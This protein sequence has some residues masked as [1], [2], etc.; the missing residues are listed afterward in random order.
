M[1]LSFD[2]VK[3]GGYVKVELKRKGNR[4]RRMQV[5]KK[6]ESSSENMVR[7]FGGRILA[8][9]WGHEDTAASVGN[10]VDVDGERRRTAVFGQATA[11]EFRESSI[12]E[13]AG[14]QANC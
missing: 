11:V 12:A 6:K 8:T 2:I 5:Q 1:A 3:E 14:I 9:L 7:A 4:S 13:L 10:S